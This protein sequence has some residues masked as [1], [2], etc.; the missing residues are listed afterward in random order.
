[1]R[2]SEETNSSL[3]TFWANFAFARI[4]IVYTV[5]ALKVTTF[6]HILLN[7]VNF[8]LNI[9]NLNW[10]SFKVREIVVVVLPNELLKFAKILYKRCSH[11]QETNTQTQEAHIKS[12]NA[13][14]KQQNIFISLLFV[15]NSMSFS[16]FDV[17]IDLIYVIHQRAIFNCQHSIV[18]LWLEVLPIFKTL[19]H[20]RTFAFKYSMWNYYSIFYI[21]NGLELFM[22]WRYL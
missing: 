8:N 10:N 17:D 22:F 2:F 16:I 6:I 14:G 3:S 13:F 19:S 21:L 9:N 18:S 12:Q 11:K 15:F 1:M 20:Y 4:R 7:S 5:Y